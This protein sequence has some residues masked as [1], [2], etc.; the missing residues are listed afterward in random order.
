MTKITDEKLLKIKLDYI[1]NRITEQDLAEK[2]KITQWELLS[3]MKD[4]SFT[5]NEKEFIDK[6]FDKVPVNGISNKGGE[7]IIIGISEVHLAELEHQDAIKKSKR[8]N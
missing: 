3:K 5:D 8:S 1:F 4:N 2:L 6:V 7:R